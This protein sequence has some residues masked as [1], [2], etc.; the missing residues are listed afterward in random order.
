MTTLPPDLTGKRF[1]CHNLGTIQCDSPVKIFYRDERIITVF[2]DKK[3]ME[4]YNQKFPNENTTC[5]VDYHIDLKEIAGIQNKNFYLTFHLLPEDKIEEYQNDPE[6]RW[7]HSLYPF[8]NYK[9]SGW[10]EVVEEDELSFYDKIF[11]DDDDI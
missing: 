6:E 7:L 11:S 8:I 3:S 1:M 4:I 5:D 10:T 9:V 2:P